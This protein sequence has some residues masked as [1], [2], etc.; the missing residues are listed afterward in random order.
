MGTG[1]PPGH[2]DGWTPLFPIFM[3]RFTCR[4]ANQADAEE[5]R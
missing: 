5:Q 1:R 3:D 4:L 2:R